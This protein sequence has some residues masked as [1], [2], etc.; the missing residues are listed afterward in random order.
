MSLVVLLGS[1]CRPC[2]CRLVVLKAWKPECPLRPRL[3][4]ELI[5]Q[6]DLEGM[7]PAWARSVGPTSLLL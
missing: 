6:L 5:H 3:G 7:A 2:V 4:R 1:T